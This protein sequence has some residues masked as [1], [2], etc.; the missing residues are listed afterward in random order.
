M[1]VCMLQYPRMLQC[2][3]LMQDTA[4][5]RCKE[6]AGGTFWQMPGLS[7]MAEALSLS[8]APLPDPRDRH[9]YYTGLL[10]D[11][12]PPDYWPVLEYSPEA[13]DPRNC[14]A[15]DLAA[16][17]FLPSAN[18]FQVNPALKQE[19]GSSSS[20]A[21]LPSR[22]E[23]E[24]LSSTC[25]GPQR[26]EDSLGVSTPSI[27]KHAKSVTK[28]FSAQP[29]AEAPKAQLPCPEDC[30]SQLAPAQG[31]S[32]VNQ[33][34]PSKTIAPECMAAQALWEQL[35]IAAQNDAASVHAASPLGESPNG[36]TIPLDGSGPKADHALQETAACKDSPRQNA[37]ADVQPS[38]E[39][40]PCESTGLQTDA[41]AAGVPDLSA[42]DVPAASEARPIGVPKAASKKKWKKVRAQ[43]SMLLHP[44][45]APNEDVKQPDALNS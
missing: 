33:S 29:A 2:N 14:P 21:S 38:P 11:G 22:R 18:A 7:K 31:S 35:P 42:K 4:N 15:L 8:G 19:P 27:S 3:G 16:W 39:S 41:E 30:S 40:T 44:N 5:T 13:L 45:L 43:T 17:P 12:T 6:M 1:A 34:S 36:V 25:S 20:L 9:G 23:A 10:D 37:S 26:T 28:P 24:G 32:G